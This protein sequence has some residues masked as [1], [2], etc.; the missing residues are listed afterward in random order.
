M[1]TA[2][3]T[4]TITEQQNYKIDLHLNGISS[5]LPQRFASQTSITVPGGGSDIQQRLAAKQKLRCLVFEI[6]GELCCAYNYTV[7][8]HNVNDLLED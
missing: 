5:Q 8:V 2:I 7:H 3:I 1:M 4:V 6:A